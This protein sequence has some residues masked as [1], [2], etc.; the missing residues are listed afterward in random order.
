MATTADR[1][2][3]I[4][5]PT[6]RYMV[7]VI[8]VIWLAYTSAQDRPELSTSPSRAVVRSGILAKTVENTKLRLIA[9]VGLEGTGHHYV[10][11]TIN[12]V[13]STPLDKENHSIGCRIGKLLYVPTLLSTPSSFAKAQS[14]LREQVHKLVEIEERMES[15]NS[16]ISM[17]N[18]CRMLS[19]PMGG[20]KDK[21]FR[22]VDLQ[23]VAEVAE[24][25]HIDFR[26]IYLQRSARQLLVSNVL[27]SGYHE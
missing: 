4:L 12:Q 11:G 6:V 8:G 26:V 27:H 13:F 5:W 7:I 18:G 17:V 16:S 25:E 1:M 9:I 24:K 3:V 14:D 20:G 23:M 15:S 22:Y 19:Y 2:M 10:K 21:V